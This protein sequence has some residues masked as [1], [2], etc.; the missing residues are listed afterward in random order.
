MQFDPAAQRVSRIDVGNTRKRFLAGQENLN[1][2]LHAN[3]QAN[4]SQKQGSMKIDDNGLAFTGQMV[5]ATL[6]TDY[7]L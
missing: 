4:L 3:L 7:D 6:D 1:G 5:G 2:D